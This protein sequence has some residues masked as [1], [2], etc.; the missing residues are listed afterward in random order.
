VVRAI[1]DAEDPAAA[2]EQLRGAFAE[3]GDVA[4]GG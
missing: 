1:R 3:I 4:P 2:A